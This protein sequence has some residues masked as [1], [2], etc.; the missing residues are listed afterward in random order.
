M[1]KDRLGLCLLKVVS[2]LLSLRS[3]WSLRWLDVC[4][5]AY[6]SEKEFAFAVR[7]GMSSTGLGSWSC[8]GLDNVQEKFQVSRKECRADFPGVSLQLLDPSKWRLAAYGG[9]CRE[10]SIKLLE[11]R[12]I[13]YAVQYAEGRF[14]LG[15]FLISLTILR[16]YW[17]SAKGVYIF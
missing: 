9:F 16:W 10:E 3:D 8:F 17:G 14:P 11:A 5:C 12:S 4:I 2:H 1:D 13:L 15:R 7:E 6:P